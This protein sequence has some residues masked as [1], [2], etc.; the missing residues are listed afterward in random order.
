M[1]L[2]HLRGLLNKIN[3]C[4][5]Y[6]TLYQL[7]EDFNLVGFTLQPTGQ[8]QILLCIIEDGS[9][10]A[11]KFFEDYIHIGSIESKFEEITPRLRECIKDFV[12]QNANMPAEVKTRTKS[13]QLAETG[14]YGKVT[15][16]AAEKI[17]EDL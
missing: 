5:N 15:R 1:I 7:E 14:L 16:T 17:A 13:W 11:K 12:C 2:Q 10:K 8:K 4:V 6:E 9:P 3:R